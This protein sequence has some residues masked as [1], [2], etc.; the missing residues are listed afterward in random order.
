MVHIDGRVELLMSFDFGCDLWKSRLLV[1]QDLIAYKS[2]WSV[3]LFLPRSWGW[4]ILDPVLMMLVYWDLVFLIAWTTLSLIP[5]AHCLEASST[6]GRATGI[7]GSQANVMSIPFCISSM[8]LL[9]ETISGCIPF[10]FWGVDLPRCHQLVSTPL[11]S[12]SWWC[13]IQIVSHSILL[14]GQ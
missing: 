10:A 13:C 8:V 7:Y 4:W 6:V 14:F 9:A 12:G 5:F 2:Q 1:S 3:R 11:D